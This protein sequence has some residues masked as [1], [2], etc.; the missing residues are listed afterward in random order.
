MLNTRN[1]TRWRTLN[2]LT[3]PRPTYDHCAV[4]LN[5][6]ALMVTGGVGQESQAVIVDLKSKRWES[7]APMKQPRRQVRI[8]S[9]FRLVEQFNSLFQHACLKA[10]INGRSGVIVAGGSSDAVPALSSVEFLD[11]RTGRWSSLGR[12][13]T[14]RRYPGVMVMAKNLLVVGGERDDRVNG[15][16]V[17]MDSMETL[18]KKNWRRVRQKLQQPMSR[19]A[20]IRIPSAFAGGI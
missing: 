18:R 1:P 11:L 5:K 19:F 12:M 17:I 3:L 9:I 2:R 4:A 6:T 8:S 20:S 7:M 10:T 14:G 13:R 16:T 15:R